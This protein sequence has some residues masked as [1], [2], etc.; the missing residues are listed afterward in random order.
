MARN[1]DKVRLGLEDLSV[2]LPAEP[3]EGV[4]TGT[5]LE[6]TST[7]A[8]DG[9]PTELDKPIIPDEEAVI[10]PADTVIEDTVSVIQ[11][12]DVPLGH[13]TSPP[14][15]FREAK[16]QKARIITLIAPVIAAQ[17][18]LRGREN[19]PAKGSF[20]PEWFALAKQRIN[21]E[22]IVLDDSVLRSQSD[23][24]K[25]FNQLKAERDDLQTFCKAERQKRVAQ[26]EAE[27]NKSNKPGRKSSRQSQSFVDER[28]G[29]SSVGQVDADELDIIARNATPKAPRTVV[30][31]PVRPA[32]PS[33]SEFGTSASP[34]PAPPS[35]SEFGTS[36]SPR[37]APP[38]PSEFVVSSE[39]ASLREELQD[40]RHQWAIV[41]AKRQGHMFDVRHKF[42]ELGARYNELVLKI[43]RIQLQ[44]QLASA[45]TQTEKNTLAIGYYVEEQKKL[46]ELTRHETEGKFINKFVGW[47]NRGSRKARVAKGIL[48]GAIIGASG[49]VLL[50][51]AG[52][53]TVAGAAMAVG[54][55]GRGYAARHNASGMDELSD[56]QLQDA[57][58]RTRLYG[59]ESDDAL[60]NSSQIFR[61]YFES[62]IKREQKKV[63]TAVTWGLGSVAV[64]VVAG[65]ALH[66]GLDYFQAT[67]SVASAKGIA[68][69][70][71]HTPL[72]VKAE[73]V[74]VSIDGSGLLDKPELLDGSSEVADLSDSQ[75]NELVTDGHD[76][77]N[78][79]DAY[80]I[81]HGE[82]WYETFK[83]MGIPKEHW[84][85]VLQDAGPELKR[86][87]WA[88]FDDANNE[89]RIS[90]SGTL[91]EQA[92][93]IVKDSSA[94][95]GYAFNR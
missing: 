13:E 40:V 73:T 4:V 63:R 19:P 26:S 7:P 75:S 86:Q 15:S 38:S 74:S 77:L 48:L 8:E 36:A 61:D 94:K 52:A 12:T 95:A 45:A 14:R 21:E 46:R 80:N 43:G 10:S 79:H 29:R 53:A 69:L 84:S 68:P 34:R 16:K 1:R 18:E 67:D 42:D 70:A 78:A 62:D 30:T 65:Q 56:V 60:V 44:E 28:D 76:L 83:D 92:M 39:L 11:P 41:S 27:K 64:G 33:P 6:Q 47:M 72:S 54:R 32:P 87:G 51:I 31:A 82:G 35:P 24:F 57:E 50:G 25:W 66:A 2:L 89:W 91:S 9:V 37:P 5:E 23:F 90:Q 49:N 22:G 93:Q 55:F 85:S 17:I 59:I 58:Y 3:N 20:L 71:D 88:Y 81:H